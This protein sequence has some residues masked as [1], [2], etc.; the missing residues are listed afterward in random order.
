MEDAALWFNGYYTA[1]GAC[2]LREIQRVHADVRPSI[3]DDHTGTDDLL[4]QDRLTLGKFSVEVQRTPDVLVGR[5]VHHYR[6]FARFHTKRRTL[7]DDPIIHVMIPRPWPNA[8]WSLD[9][10]D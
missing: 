2:G 5:V 4:K 7:E 9:Q 10:Y 6:V 3:D 1:T 8:T